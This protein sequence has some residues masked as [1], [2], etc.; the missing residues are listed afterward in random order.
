MK[1]TGP[2][3]ESV[4]L[5]IQLIFS[6]N[7]FSFL[8]LSSI[9]CFCYETYSGPVK[10]SVCPG[11]QLMLSLSRL[12]ERQQEELPQIYKYQFRTKY[13]R[14][15]TSKYLFSRKSEYQNTNI[16]NIIQLN[17]LGLLE[18]AKK[19]A[20]T[21]L[22]YCLSRKCEKNRNTNIIQQKV[23][24][25]DPSQTIFHFKEACETQGCN[26]CR[27]LQRRGKL[28]IESEKVG[29]AHSLTGISV[30]CGF[31]K[32][33]RCQRQSLLFQMCIFQMKQA[34][35]RLRDLNVS[36]ILRKVKPEEWGI[37]CQC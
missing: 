3:K 7:T 2:V 11:I 24:S 22:W 25:F 19:E 14:I 13:L 10:E 20:A 9:Q 23:L 28:G 31:I 30:T 4:C 12:L 16:T 35:I 5:R 32:T 8:L 1:P 21:G 33:C 29:V 37:Q 27:Y 17:N 34:Y 15:L 36:K 26:V 18:K 6:L